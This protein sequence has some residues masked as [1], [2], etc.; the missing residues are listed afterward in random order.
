MIELKTNIESINTE[1]GSAELSISC[2]MAGTGEE[3]VHE[4]LASIRALNKHLRE[5]NK[6]LH[7]MVLSEIASDS[8]IL[9]GEEPEDDDVDERLVAEFANMN[10]KNIIKK[11]VN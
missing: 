8:S 1:K 11:G 7:M 5:E 9:L 4:V 3:L 10:S 2:R 6:L